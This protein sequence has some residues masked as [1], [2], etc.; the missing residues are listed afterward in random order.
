M[1]VAHWWSARHE[2]DGLAGA[3]LDLLAREVVVGP[4]RAATVRAIEY[5]DHESALFVSS[6]S[7]L[8][9]PA[10]EKSKKPLLNGSCGPIIYI[11]VHGSA[12]W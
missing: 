10:V 9:P 2:Q 7:S 6:S 1:P 5:H 3:A 12:A 4:Q 8:L 11:N